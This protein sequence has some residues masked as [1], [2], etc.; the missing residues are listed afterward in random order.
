[1][2]RNKRWRAAEADDR[3]RAAAGGGYWRIGKDGRREWVA[4]RQD[5][6]PGVPQQVVDEREKY[7]QGELW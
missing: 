7:H 1:M 5:R 3:A 2:G 4:V 6:L